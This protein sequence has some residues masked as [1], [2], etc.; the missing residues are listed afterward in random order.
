VYASRLRPRCSARSPQ[1]PKVL[2]L[3]DNMLGAISNLG[4]SAQL[5]RYFFFLGMIFYPVDT[6]IVFL[7]WGEPVGGYRT[8]DVVLRK[9][10]PHGGIA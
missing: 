4:L 9:L 2:S 8:R 3:R 7:V 5:T 10:H 1:S 6:V